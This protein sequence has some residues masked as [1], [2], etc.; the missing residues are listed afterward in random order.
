ME[1]PETAYDRY[2][3]FRET[4]YIP[5]EISWGGYDKPTP[6]SKSGRLERLRG[7]N[8]KVKK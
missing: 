1:K 7:P 5:P 8:E 2:L 3:K 4:V 6:Q